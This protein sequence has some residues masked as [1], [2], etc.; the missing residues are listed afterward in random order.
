MHTKHFNKIMIVAGLVIF[1]ISG[2]DISSYFSKSLQTTTFKETA[3][4][5]IFKTIEQKPKPTIINYDPSNLE[6]PI[7]MY[8]HVDYSNPD[9]KTAS[10]LAVSLKK[11]QNQ[12]DLIQNLGYTTINFQNIEDGEIPEKAIILTF[13]DAY[14]DFY[15]KAFPELQKRNMTAVIYLPSNK[16]NREGYMTFAQVKELRGNNIEIGSHS[17]NHADLGSLDEDNLRKEIFD[18]KEFL[19]K[20]TD[21]KILSFCY[22]YGIYNSHIRSLLEESGYKYGLTTKTGHAKFD[23]PLDLS[24]HKVYSDTDINWY[25]N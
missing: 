2:F 23:K 13:D 19:E 18:S 16:L 10:Y 14:E 20:L 11:L 3:K 17:L 12:L 22:P 7:F 21:Q 24:R 4:P 25:I 9:Q 8:H 5:E 6:I 15:T 1:G